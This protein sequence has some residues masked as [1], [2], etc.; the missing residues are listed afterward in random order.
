MVIDEGIEPAGRGHGPSF[1][2]G[3]FDQ[4]ELD[5]VD[6]A[7]KPVILMAASGSRRPG[8][9]AGQSSGRRW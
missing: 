3:E 5:L 7:G 6:L 4:T 8:G 1:V 2:L 9:V